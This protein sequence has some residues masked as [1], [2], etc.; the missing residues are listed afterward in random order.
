MKTLIMTLCQF[1][2][3]IWLQTLPSEFDR[4]IYTNG[5]KIFDNKM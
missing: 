2:S 3:S 4:D 5:E 1:V